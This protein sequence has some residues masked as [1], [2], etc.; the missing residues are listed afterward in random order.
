[1]LSADKIALGENH[2]VNSGCAELIFFLFGFESLALQ[3]A[4][5]GRSFDAST[6]LNQGDIG[7]ANVKESAV[8][9]LLH[10]G[11]L[12]ASRK[13]RA[14]VVGLSGAIA[15]GNLQ[16]HVHGVVGRSS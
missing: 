10:H 7:I 9:E 3:F 16:V 1:A 15:N 8:F 13:N 14:L 4:G 12:L 2:V 11:L 5:F 6:I